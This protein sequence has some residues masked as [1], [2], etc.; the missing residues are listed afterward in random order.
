VYSAPAVLLILPNTDVRIDIVQTASQST[1]SFTA[2]FAKMSH[3]Q[4]T[5]SSLLAP[6]AASSQDQDLELKGVECRSL[7][8]FER[9]SSSI[10]VTS[11]FKEDFEEPVPASSSHLSIFSVFHLPRIAK[12]SS[13]S[14]DGSSSNDDFLALPIPQ[15]QISE[16]DFVDDSEQ[17][18]APKC[19]SARLSPPRRSSQRPSVNP[20]PWQL[21]TDSTTAMWQKAIRRSID[22]RPQELRISSIV[23]KSPRQQSIYCTA[24]KSQVNLKGKQLKTLGDNEGFD[25]MA[26]LQIVTD[27]GE[28]QKIRDQTADHTIQLRNNQLLAQEGEAKRGSDLLNRC[29]PVNRSVTPPASWTR[30]PSHNREERNESAAASDSVVSNDFAVKTLEDGSIEYI[31]SIRKHLHRHHEKDHHHKSLPVRFSMKIRASLD[32][33][34]TTKSTLRHDVIVGRRSSTSI[35][36]VLESPELE[37]LPLAPGS[38]HLRET[39]LEVSAS[40]RRASRQRRRMI[41]PESD[42]GFGFDGGSATRVRVVDHQFYNDCVSESEIKDDARSAKSIRSDVTVEMAMAEYFIDPQASKRSKFNT[43]SGRER[44]AFV[45]ARSVLRQSTIDITKELEKMEVLERE[46][47]LSMAEEAFGKKN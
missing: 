14:Y 10:P 41:S 4:K 30:F 39:Q 25:E 38:G 23:P 35:G 33:L 37:I 46:R 21:S 43:W 24:Q 31:T 19:S 44:N 28:T 2:P 47:A 26:Q 12:L 18:T 3:R 9:R 34:R 11:K 16:H 29:R 45:D 1:S 40:M 13:K 42:E 5:D 36:G 27:L 15:I 32:K 22:I 20:N 8:L 6:E 17:V 7:G